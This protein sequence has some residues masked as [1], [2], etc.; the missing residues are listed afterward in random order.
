MT[1]LAA[2]PTWAADSVFVQGA[3]NGRWGASFPP[4]IP[5]V[6]GP[7]NFS[8]INETEGI[9]KMDGLRSPRGTA[10]EICPPSD[11]K[12]EFY[13]GEYDYNKRGEVYACTNGTTLVGVYRDFD[14][15]DFGSILIDETFPGANPNW[16]GTFTNAENETGAMHGVYEGGGIATPL[17]RVAAGNGNRLIIITDSP[18]PSATLDVSY[19]SGLAASG[20]MLPYAWS[21]A[22]GAL[23]PDLLLDAVTGAIEGTP[24]EAGVFDWV[25]EVSDAAGISTAKGF[26]ISVQAD[27]DE[28]PQLSVQPSRLS[29]SY[30]QVSPATTKNLSVLNSGGGSMGFEV[31]VATQSGGPWLMVSPTA[32][33][34][35]AAERSMLNV[36]VDPALLAPGTYFGEIQIA[37]P[38][39]QQ[40]MTVP[41]AMTIS[42]RSQLLRL[43]Q[44]GLAFT[45][46]VGAGAAPVQNL[47]VFNDG[48]G[49]MP[50]DIRSET[51]SGGDWLAV[52]PST[53]AS[54]PSI[55]ATV[56]VTIRSQ[57]LPPGAYYALLE[58]AS[59]DAANSP[60]FTTVVLNQLEG[61]QDPGAIV[62]PRGLI[63]ASTPTSPAP[64]A[65]SFRISNLTNGPIGFTLR[66][67][68]LTGDDWLAPTTT[69]GIVSPG[70]PA[71]I[72]V[73]VQTEGLDAGIYRGLLN[74]QFDGGRTQAVDVRLVVSP[75]AGAGLQPPARI[76][77]GAC[78]RT[79]VA[80]VFRVLGGTSPIPAGWPTN[81]EVEVVDNC[82]DQMA[83]GSVVADFTNISSPS[84]ALEHLGS[85]LWGA[86]WN[87][88][89]T[90]DPDSNAVVT[91]TAT[92]PAGVSGALTQALSV[93]TNSSSPPRVAPGGVRHSASFVVDP[94]APGTIV[95]IFGSNLSSELVSGGGRSASGVPLSTELAGTQMI[96]G[97]R[98]LPILFSREDQVNAVL[99]FEVADRLNESLP[100]LVRRTDT[101]SLGVSEPVLV[102]AARP[103][104]FTQNAS[105]SGLGSIQNASF[106]IVT[107][108]RPAKG[109]DAIV[110]YGTGL[111]AV[112]PEVASGDPAP[113]SPLARTA[114]ATVTIGGRA[115]QVI[116]AGLTPGFTSL[117][118][119]NAVVP[120]GVPAGEAEV[121]VSIAGQAS[122]VVTL[123]VE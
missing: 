92:D 66:G 39:T 91:V 45:A 38:A 35:T 95:S 78:S 62:D 40:S 57:G 94:L 120:A 90:V 28:P 116:F 8:Q 67:L 4:F 61:D 19:S 20:G 97:G 100:L 85:G 56:D 122:P 106:Q 104:V 103:G 12:R 93:S 29:F 74:L 31:D 73:E 82:A 81:I 41:V 64:P 37:S 96:L 11:E 119:V 44:S 86:T 48:L 3:F 75:E 69:D 112:S 102:T 18:L 117:Y 13:G 42:R 115:A 123:A 54:E 70:E 84:L 23:P 52:G 32:G 58:V 10:A 55:P 47:R 107:P 33:E 30:V 83:E 46:V 1:L 49:M 108:A 59:P 2:A 113:S 7:I 6:I 77:Q 101:A 63:F 110:I 53:G 24:T 17:A 89:S 60:Q 15:S 71:N 36:T 87:V 111:G 121:V 26:I 27:A 34:T 99:P 76:S 22:A 50:W 88:P 98:S 14:G 114:D 109:R 65:Q 68:T 72:G 25:A 79:E 80:P 21:V 51:L 5:Q 118:Q 9:A 105:G 16:T 43:S